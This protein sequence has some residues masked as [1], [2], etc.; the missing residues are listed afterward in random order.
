MLLT[1]TEYLTNMP[2]DILNEYGLTKTLLTRRETIYL[3]HV[4][5]NIFIY[6]DEEYLKSNYKN[7]NVL[8]NNELIQNIDLIYDMITQKKYREAKEALQNLKSH[9][10][11]N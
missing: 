11:K 4:L 6:G 10:N 2:T 5:K 1:K 9:I 8:N 7:K 3:K